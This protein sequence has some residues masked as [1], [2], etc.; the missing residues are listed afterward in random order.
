MRTPG[1]LA[2]TLLALSA[3]GESASDED[4]VRDAIGD[5]AKAVS[6][7]E[8]ERVCELLVTRAGERPPERCRD[9]VEVVAWRPGSR[10]VRWRY[11]RSA[12]AGQ[13][14]WLLWRAASASICGAST[15]P[16]GS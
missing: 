6:G 2:L 1:A 3:C 4:Q 15:G 16:G 5:Y 8:P 13:P 7:N 10:R 11:V 14:P 9:R 12:C